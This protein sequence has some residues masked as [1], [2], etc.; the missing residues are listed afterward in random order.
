MFL[1]AETLITGGNL[2][3]LYIAVE[4]SPALKTSAQ[5]KS[6]L[7]RELEK[8]DQEYPPSKHEIKMLVISSVLRAYEEMITFIIEARDRWGIEW[9]EIPEDMIVCT[10]KLDFQ[11]T[12]FQEVVPFIKHSPRRKSLTKRLLTIFPYFFKKRIAA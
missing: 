8:V 10:I 9:N 3:T 1:N 12:T 4:V 2:A 6:A 7:K 11:A 5:I